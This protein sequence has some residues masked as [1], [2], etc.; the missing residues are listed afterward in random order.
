MFDLRNKDKKILWLDV[1][2]FLKQLDWVW[3]PL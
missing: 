2:A 3:L 1:G